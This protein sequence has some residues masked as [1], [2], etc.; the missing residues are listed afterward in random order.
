MCCSPVLMTR[1]TASELN[2][3]WVP[4]S[5]TKFHQRHCRIKHAP[6]QCFINRIGNNAK[7]GLNVLN[8]TLDLF[9]F[10]GQCIIT[11]LAWPELGFRVR[12]FKGGFNET[13][14]LL[15][16]YKSCPHHKLSSI[17]IDSQLGSNGLLLSV[18]VFERSGSRWS[19]IHDQRKGPRQITFS[20]AGALWIS[21]QRGKHVFTSEVDWRYFRKKGGLLECKPNLRCFNEKVQKVKQGQVC[22]VRSSNES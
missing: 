8:S 22:C 20:C 3:N 13:R 21:R 1:V 18:C 11:N 12:S 9:L 19:L 15:I 2:L 7:Q 16:S 4:P 5:S 6:I 10:Y 14:P 17:H